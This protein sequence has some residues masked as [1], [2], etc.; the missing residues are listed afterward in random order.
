MSL[1]LKY[2]IFDGL[3]IYVFQILFAQINKLLTEMDGTK[4][5]TDKINLWCISCSLFSFHFKVFS[6][7]I[8]FGC[9]CCWDRVLRVFNITVTVSINSAI[10]LIKSRVIMNSVFT[11]KL[12]PRILGTSLVY[13]AYPCEIPD[14]I[15]TPQCKNLLNRDMVKKRQR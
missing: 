10:I 11:S 8:P 6:S 13:P 5:T 1:S 14:G 3:Y 7:F 15:Q 12:F 4:Y 9:I 2:T